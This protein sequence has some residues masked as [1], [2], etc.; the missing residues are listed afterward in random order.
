VNGRACGQEVIAPGDCIECGGDLHLQR[1]GGYPA[2]FGQVCSE[3]CAADQTDRLVAV[4]R[5]DHLRLRDLLC[6][7]TE[8]CAPAGL[9][10]QA[11]LDEYAAW[12]AGGGR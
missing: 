3:D 12:V 4:A 2:K 9:P 11:M 5:A 7:C 10:S 6:A 8:V 1:A